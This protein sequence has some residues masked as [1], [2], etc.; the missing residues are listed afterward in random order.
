[1]IEELTQEEIDQYIALTDKIQKIEK[2]IH[3]EELA[4]NKNYI[5]QTAN[6]GV[7]PYQLQISVTTNV[8]AIQSDP[9]VAPLLSEQFNQTY[10]I[11][12]LDKSYT[13]IVDSLYDN[14]T[15]LLEKS[16]SDIGYNKTDNKDEVSV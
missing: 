2:A 13:P 5:E 16:C 10:I 9:H 4:F 8:Y 14:M 11:D 1:M 3:E 6:S 12:F 15:K 7:I